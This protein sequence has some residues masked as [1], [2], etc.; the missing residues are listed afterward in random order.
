M[1][2]A[3]AAGS[4]A[5]EGARAPV[6][7]NRYTLRDLLIEVFYHRRVMLIAFAGPVALGL[8]AALMS[9]PAYVA[10]ARLLVLY[11]SEYI[12]R[13]ITG[14]PGSSVS[15]DRNQIIQGELQVLQS[16]TLAIETLQDVGLERVYPGTKA[17]GARVLQ[18]AAI[19]FAKDLSLSSI[20][21]SNILELSF[22]SHDPAVS[23]D[24]LRALI[25][26][27]LQRRVAV[28]ERPPSPTAQTDQSKFL[29][30][31]HA[32][33]DAY[34]NFAKAHG[35]G[36][37]DEQMLLLLRQQSSNSQARDDAA[38]AARETA[39][40]L[41]VVQQQLSTVPP[42]VSLFTEIDRSRKTQVLSENLAQMQIKRRDLEMRYQPNYTPLVDLGRQITALEQQIARE[43][44]REGA[45]ARSGRNP[46][47][48][49]VQQQ[50]MALQAQSDGD[51]ARQAELADAGAAITARV[52]AF[53][54]AGPE[55]RDLLRNRDVL[56]ETY[57]AYVRS[58]EEM[59]I[60]DAAE[61]SR[62]ANV[63]V[64]Q[65]PEIP[66]A[67]RSLRVILAAA[68]IVVGLIAAVAAL[69]VSN[70]LK[71]VFVT[72]RDA[73][74]S[75]ELPVLLAVPRR[76]AKLDLAGRGKLGDDGAF[77]T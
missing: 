52:K 17:D 18:D 26:G 19:R 4:V 24:V 43:P 8:V 33:E 5:S 62:A 70:A 12:Y 20:P 9:R 44:G 21:Q 1:S 7:L 41:A 74:V 56:D 38:N 15:L 23:A 50:A 66:A 11:G 45:D 13:P 32:A 65:P 29:E 3:V 68:G 51:R 34:A 16:T 27:Y 42:T 37:F 6:P 25:A 36:N 10:Q 57:R 49:D 48:Q 72:V 47:Y 31:L 73:S 35:I 46:V 76:L 55:Y 69:A 39:A 61:R 53:A 2:G 54:E 67:S 58:N 60:A 77:S 64:V 30:R 59:Q 14:Q 75:L 63:R 22:R 40:K 71:Q 28:F